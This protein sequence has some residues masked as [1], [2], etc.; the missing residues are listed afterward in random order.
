VAAVDPTTGAAVTAFATQSPKYRTFQ[1]ATDGTNVFAAMGGPGGRLRAYQPD[2]S[3]LWEDTADGDVQACTYTDRLVIIGGHF[4]SLEQAKRSQ[5]GAADATNGSLDTWGPGM[6][7]SI[8]SLNADANGVYVG[9]TFTRVDGL[10]QAGF[11]R[12][13][14]A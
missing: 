10:V 6:N 14:P 13:P 12:F 8:W 4:A 1:L 3:I 9:G 5:I 11:T 2:G 7:G